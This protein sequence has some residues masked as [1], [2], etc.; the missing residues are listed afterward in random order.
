MELGACR[1]GQLNW[2][3]FYMIHLGFSLQSYEKA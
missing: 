2:H 3:E 1:T